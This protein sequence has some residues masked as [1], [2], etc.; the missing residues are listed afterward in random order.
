MINSLAY[1]SFERVSQNLQSFYQLRLNRIHRFRAKIEI[2]TEVGPFEIKTV[3]NVEELKEA[4][5]LR[6]DVFHKEMLGK[7]AAQGVDVD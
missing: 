2:H 4:L 5:A 1:T 7:K 3:T 6:Y